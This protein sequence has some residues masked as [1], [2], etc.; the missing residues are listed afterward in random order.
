MTNQ[1]NPALDASIECLAPDVRLLLRGAGTEDRGAIFWATFSDDE[2][3][4][5]IVYRSYK[6]D[7]PQFFSMLAAADLCA[8]VVNLRRLGLKKS[9]W[10]LD[11]GVLK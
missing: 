8:G 7:A 2:G 11:D 10:G 6:E 9:F 4:T 5:R 3:E 1:P